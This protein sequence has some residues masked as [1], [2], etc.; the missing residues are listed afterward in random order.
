M[1]LSRKKPTTVLDL[2]CKYNLPT[3]T[4]AAAR[5]LVPKKPAAL[6][7]FE[8]DATVRE[9]VW[10]EL[11]HVLT[12][13]GMPMKKRKRSGTDPVSRSCGSWT[14]CRT[15]R[16][17]PGSGRLWRICFLASCRDWKGE[18]RKSSRSCE[19]LLARKWALDV[20]KTRHRTV[21]RYRYTSAVLSLS[22][23]IRVQ[24]LNEDGVPLRSALSQRNAA[25]GSGRYTA[26]LDQALFFI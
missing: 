14:R 22:L 18:G 1:T 25:P 26:V 13:E 6:L 17:V 8:D 11:F 7:P 3:S 10:D 9:V 4:Q 2:S 20:R 15:T 21:S 24:N 23:K 12:G 19:L 5:A 16:G